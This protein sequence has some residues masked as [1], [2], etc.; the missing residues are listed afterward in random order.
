MQGFIINC[1]LIFVCFSQAISSLYAQ[2]AT[3][4]VTV[5][6]S[7]STNITENGSNRRVCITGGTYTGNITLNGTSNSIC[8]G[9]GATIGTGA[10]FSLNGSNIT[11]DNHGTINLSS[12]S[13]NTGGTFNN[14]G[15]TNITGTLNLNGNP[16]AYN[17][18]S[19]VTNLTNAF[20]VNT[21]ATLSISGGNFNQTSNGAFSNNNSGGTISISN[22]AKL[23]IAGS[24]T[25][26]G[27]VNIQL[28]TMNVGGNFT[29]NS[30]ASYSLN[31]G[32]LTV[33]GNATNNG[34][35]QTSGGSC[36]KM[37]IAGNITNNSSGNISGTIGAQIDMCITGSVTNTGTIANRATNCS[38]NSAALP[39][40][41]VRFVGKTI[42]NSSR[43]ALQWLAYSDESNSFFEIQKSVNGLDFQTVDKKDALK[44]SSLTSYEWI[45]DAP[46]THQIQYYR[47]RMIS[48]NQMDYSPIVAVT[49]TSTIV[50]VYPNPTHDFIHIKTVNFLQEPTI[51]LHDLRGNNIKIPII[52]KQHEYE[53]D[54]HTLPMGVYMLKVGTYI[55]RVVVCRQL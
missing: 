27:T 11:I 19:G 26:N 33:G 35:I 23:N 14:R 48:P 4:D 55:E 17:Q 28:G 47:L 13:L 3:C 29:N 18:I 38:C 36:S 41:L 54:I 20:N 44:G 22:M 51:S 30:S 31:N 50:T 16:S 37:Q 10:S 15:T 34:V 24:F 46:I 45:D 21:N 5:S 53:I 6:T 39:I 32:L 2:C 49:S 42:D 43:I 1:I 8:I 7:S 12:L 52:K 40:T 9:S 25:N